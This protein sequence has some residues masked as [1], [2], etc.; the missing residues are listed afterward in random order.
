V[1]T[2][3]RTVPSSAVGVVGECGASRNESILFVQRLGDAA[4]QTAL[5]FVKLKLF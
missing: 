1:V 4:V 3:L 5:A 2:A